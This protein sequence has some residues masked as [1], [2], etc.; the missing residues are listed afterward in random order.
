[1]VLKQFAKNLLLWTIDYIKPETYYYSF[2]INIKT[3]KK[4]KI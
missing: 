4:F 2:N 1:M 3:L